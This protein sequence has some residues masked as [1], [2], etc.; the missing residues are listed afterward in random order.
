MN[1]QMVFSR[2]LSVTMAALVLLVVACSTIAAPNQNQPPGAETSATTAPARGGNGPTAQ[3]KTLRVA[4]P[5]FSEPADPI[6]G[7]FN[8]TKTGLSE[9]LF[10]LGR[11]LESE[12]WLATG[13]HQ[14]DERTWEFSLRQSV[15]FHDGA[16]MDAA[17]VKASLERAI[18]ESAT[19]RTLLDIARIDVKDSATIIVTTIDPSP[20][21]PAMLAEP[22]SGI[23]SAAAA[24]AMGDAFAAQPVLTGPFKVERFRPNEELVAV[25]HTEY[26]GDPPLVDRVI[27]KVL[28]D[29]SSR[30]LAVQ[31]GD[32]DIA[33][34]IAPESVATVSRAPNLA[35]R[36]ASPVALEFIYLD[37][38]K[39]PWRDARV[40]RA[41]AYSIDR[42]ALVDS[43]MQGAGIPADGPFAP[44]VVQCP[45]VQ[46]H[47]FDPAQARELLSQA[48]YQDTNGD[49]MVEKIGQPLT[50]ELL[51]YPQ[52]PELPAI[53]QV[54][55]ANLKDI[56]IRVNI[57]LVE[58]IDAA[59]EQGDWD[60]GMYFNNMAVTGDPYRPLSVFFTTNGPANRGVYSNPQ[61]DEMVRRINQAKEREERERLACEAS[62]AIVNDLPVI[63]LLHPN[64]S[65]AV[66]NDVIGFDQ[67]HPLFLYLMHS[68]IGKR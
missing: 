13:A 32:V 17:A 1:S 48:G 20:V 60:G 11:D 41:I 26:W 44:A 65:Y 14:L 67:P 22:T 8:P 18:A 68:K 59:L 21:L 2:F 39:E 12:P 7:G 61:I 29:N 36:S 9:T 46:G 58:G 25:R 6:K 3:D 55:Q 28:A 38:R 33:E 63:P 42:E 53:A 23:V 30:V 50:M 47:P 34:Y 51:T 66:S 56:G 10:K 16:L 37:H 31:S 19:A 54:V 24:E 4:I 15:K 57:R 27:F 62:Q 45:Q 40:R 52:R 43:V 64:Y 49:G 35:V 5:F